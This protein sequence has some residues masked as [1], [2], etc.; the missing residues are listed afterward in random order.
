MSEL[1][2][3]SRNGNLDGVRGLLSENN[4]KADS[5]EFNNYVDLAIFSGSDLGVASHLLEVRR[6]SSAP[7]MLT[8]ALDQAVQANNTGGKYVR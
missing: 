2:T 6:S 3:L 8:R 5:T 1:V 7:Y 4:H